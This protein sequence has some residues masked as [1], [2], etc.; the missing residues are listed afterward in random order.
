MLMILLQIQR[1]VADIIREVEQ[2]IQL[3]VHHYR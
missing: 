2:Q 1:E 3:E